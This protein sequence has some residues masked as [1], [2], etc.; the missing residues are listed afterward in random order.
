MHLLKL[1]VV[2]LLLVGCAFEVETDDMTGRRIP[3]PGA[4]RARVGAATPESWGQEKTFRPG[5]LPLFPQSAVVLTMPPLGEWRVPRTQ[6]LI[7]GVEN[8]DIDAN[9]EYFLRWIL[10]SGAGGARTQVVFDALGFTRLSVPLEQATL[11]L[12]YEPWSSAQDSPDGIVQAHAYLGDFGIGELDPGPTYTARFGL[13]PAP[14]PAASSFETVLIPTGARRFRVLGDDPS[15]GV[16]PVTISPFRSTVIYQ[17]KQ[18]STTVA[19]FV[20][21]RAA[22]TDGNSLLSLYYSGGFIPI[23]AGVTKFLISNSDTANSVVGWLQF[24]LDL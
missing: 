4:P 21:G 12:A 19:Q 11:S 1:I 16:G 5:T 13:P 20:G 23:P 7:V 6:T 24:G 10:K 18:G 15:V 17:L 14:N 2:A 3:M 22:V 9:Q 8:E